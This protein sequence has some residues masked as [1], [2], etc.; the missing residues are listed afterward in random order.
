MHFSHWLS[1]LRH[2]RHGRLTPKLVWW[3]FRNIEPVG[4]RV[5][6]MSMFVAYIDFE[7]WFQAFC[8]KLQ[9]LFGIFILFYYLFSLVQYS[10]TK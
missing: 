10:Q 5:F 8:P 4:E 9:F 3:L 1:S 2:S 7:K 6:E